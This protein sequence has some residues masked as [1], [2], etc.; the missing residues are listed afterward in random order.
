[1]FASVQKHVQYK[2]WYLTI[3]P[4]SMYICTEDESKDANLT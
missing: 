3:G 2:I 1:M 4:V